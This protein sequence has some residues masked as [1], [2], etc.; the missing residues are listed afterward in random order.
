[1]VKDKFM[2]ERGRPYPLG[3]HIINREGVNFAVFSKNAEALELLFFDSPKD[4]LPSQIFML[5][6]M[7]NK[8]G[9]IWHIYIHNVGHRQLY[10]YRA[11]GAYDPQEGPI[12]NQNKLLTDPYAKS[13][14]GEYKWDNEE[15]FAYDKKSPQ[16]ISTKDN[17]SS[18]VKSVVIDDYLFDWTD[19]KLLRY[20]LE[21]CIIYEMHVR[22]FTVDPS[23]QVQNKGTYRGIIE[24]IPYFKELGVTT[25]E[26]MPIQ[27]F[28]HNENIKVNPRTGERL[29]NYWGYSTL[30]FFCTM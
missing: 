4:S 19:D 18:T 26:L 20:T 10:G 14:A 7:E 15:S 23:S 30:S 27:E 13:I 22:G 1:M 11:Y 29:N 12:F 2:A 6:P 5:D 8:T 24:K 17:M 28:N 16:K 21:D 9:D 3:A 25:L